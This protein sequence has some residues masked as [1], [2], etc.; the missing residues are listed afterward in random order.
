MNLHELYIN[1]ISKE[2]KKTQTF[3][4]EPKRKHIQL[5]MIT[6]KTKN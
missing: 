5:K 4:Q 2:I 3:A 1:E 6:Y